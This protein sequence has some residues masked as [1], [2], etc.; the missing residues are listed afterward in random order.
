MS[1]FEEKI[2]SPPQKKGFFPTLN[3]FFYH[4]IAFFPLK[5]PENACST[6]FLPAK[7]QKN[8]YFTIKN[9][10]ESMLGTVLYVKICIF[11]LFLYENRRFFFPQYIRKTRK[12]KTDIISKILKKSLQTDKKIY[13]YYFKKFIFVD[14]NFFYLFLF[15]LLQK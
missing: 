14:D 11:A 12:K 2:T 8:A 10:Y 15:I 1:F 5:T 4:L 7:T 6:P 3:P 13:N 9:S